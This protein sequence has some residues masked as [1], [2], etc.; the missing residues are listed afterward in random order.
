MS[1][2]STILIANNVLNYNTNTSEKNKSTPWEN[3]HKLSLY[4]GYWFNTKLGR[5]F[6]GNIIFIL[7]IIHTNPLFT[8]RYI[9][10]N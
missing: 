8:V 7:I 1:P 9:V 10:R 4:C 5:N 3:Q 6:D 2:F